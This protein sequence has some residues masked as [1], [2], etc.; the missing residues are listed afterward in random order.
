MVSLGRQ[1]RAWD[2]WVIGLR[3]DSAFEWVNEKTWHLTT[4]EC[5]GFKPEIKN[6]HIDWV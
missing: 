3:H 4:D 5:T 2:R 1:D 6:V